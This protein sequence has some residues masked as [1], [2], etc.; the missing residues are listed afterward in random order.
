MPYVAELIKHMHGRVL[1]PPTKLLI[2]G[3]R[4]K[5]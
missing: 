4:L 2:P 5:A 1:K 3:P